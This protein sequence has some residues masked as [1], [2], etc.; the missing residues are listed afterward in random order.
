M[1]PEARARQSTDALLIAA[2]WAVQD[3]KQARIVV[4]AEAEFAVDISLRR[5]LGLSVA[6]QAN[7]FSVNQ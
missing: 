5:T 7:A 1:T 6:A 4:E 2:V 3:L